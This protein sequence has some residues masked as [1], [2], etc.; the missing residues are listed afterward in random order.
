MISIEAKPSDSDNMNGIVVDMMG[1][2]IPDP[3]SVEVRV[4]G[5][6]MALWV[7]GMY[8]IIKRKIV[9]PVENL[10]P[11]AIPL[12]MKHSTFLIAI[13]AIFCIGSNIEKAAREIAPR[14]LAWTRFFCFSVRYLS[15]TLCVLFLQ[16]VASL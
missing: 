11:D 10:K 2:S 8:E 14:M 7:L 12:R 13:M 9:L 15:D 16:V 4:V 5:F 3:Y 6:V 1:I